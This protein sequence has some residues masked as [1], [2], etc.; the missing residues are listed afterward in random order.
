M[1]VTRS[2]IDGLFTIEPDVFEDDR[3]YF[4]ESFNSKAFENATGVAVEFV[5]DN[6]SMS[7]K[8]VLR[9]L[10]FQIPPYAQDKL[11]RVVRGSVLDVAVDLRQDSP[12]F[13]KFEKVL[14]TEKNKKQFFVPKG[15]AHGFRVLEDATIFSYKCSDFYHRDSERSLKWNDPTIGI[16]WELND[17][18]LSD[19][20]KNAKL[21]LGDF[22]TTFQR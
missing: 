9:G 14:L 17:P 10:H 5:Q 18:I 13:G 1:K 15:F 3:G 4:F 22:R 6:E 2:N 21:R 8:D 7:D 19:K 12:T 16:D 20:D 11:V